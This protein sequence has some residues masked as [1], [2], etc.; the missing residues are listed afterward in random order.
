[1]TKYETQS[2]DTR[3][4]GNQF[5]S[6]WGQCLI[7]PSSKS[8]WTGRGY[9]KSRP[10]SRGNA[11]YYSRVY[12]S[13][14]LS[15]IDNVVITTSHDPNILSVTELKSFIQFNKLST[16]NNCHYH[17]LQMRKICKYLILILLIIQSD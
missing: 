12:H 15:L 13:S 3:L 14:S 16:V 17:Y 11:E 5:S 4:C 1:M 2:H 6:F 8:Y 9:P 10:E 7:R